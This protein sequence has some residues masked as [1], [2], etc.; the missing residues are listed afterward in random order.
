[1]IGFAVGAGVTGASFAGIT[2]IDGNSGYALFA[3]L[4]GAFYGG[5]GGGLIGAIIRAPVPDAAAQ[6]IVTP[7]TGS[8]QAAAL[9]V[10]LALP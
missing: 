1:M 4:A 5:L 2:M 6:L 8:A 10:S 7:P 3:F 9:S